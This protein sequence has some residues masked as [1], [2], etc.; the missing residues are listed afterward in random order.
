MKTFWKAERFNINHYF[1][2]TVRNP[3]SVLGVQE[4]ASEEEVHQ[5]YREKV[6]EVHPD[7]GGSAEEFKTVRKAYECIIDGQEDRFEKTDDDSRDVKRPRISQSHVLYLNYQ[8]VKSNG[9]DFEEA[10]QKASNSNLPEEDFGSFVMSA[11]K[12]VL[13]AAEENGLD[14]PYSCRGGA[15]ANCAV[16]VV[17]GRVKTAGYYILSGKHL[18]DG[19][20]LSCIGKPLTKKVKLVFNV[21]HMDELQ[22]MLLPSRSE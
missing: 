15:C 20:R 4:N 16:K 3:Y 9:W 12:T 21:K 13:E 11:E 10:F 1:V 18:D 5:A 19:L 8:T 2:Y 6:K 17:E 22:D 14:W 7:T